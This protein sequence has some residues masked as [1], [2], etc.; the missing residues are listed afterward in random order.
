MLRINLKNQIEFFFTEDHF[1]SMLLVSLI[2]EGLYYNM[3]AE[4]WSA[5]VFSWLCPEYGKCNISA[6]SRLQ[7]G[8]ESGSPASQG[9]GTLAV[10]SM[11]VILFV[12][13]CLFVFLPNIN[14]VESIPPSPTSTFCAVRF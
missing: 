10:L 2:S 7:Q 11:Y 8:N 4:W 12:F 9:C 3:R 5:N 13:V 14:V 6:L 1:C